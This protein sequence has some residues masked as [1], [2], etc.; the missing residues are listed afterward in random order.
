MYDIAKNNC[1]RA[2]LIEDADEIDTTSME[3]C[4]KVGV[5]AG[6]STPRSSIEEDVKKLE[7]YEK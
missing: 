6:A 4:N 5:M 7:D 3:N 1:Q 2:V